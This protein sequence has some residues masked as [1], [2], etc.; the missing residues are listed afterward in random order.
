MPLIARLVLGL[1]GDV[2]FDAT[3]AQVRGYESEINR[4]L[5]ERGYRRPRPA[6][7]AR[8]K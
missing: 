4:Y 2:L 7:S 5:D 1:V 8:P 6:G 3:A